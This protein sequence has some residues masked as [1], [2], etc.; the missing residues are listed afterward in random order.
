MKQIINDLQNKIITE[1]LYSRLCEERSE[2]LE[3]RVDSQRELNHYILDRIEDVL[4]QVEIL[5]MT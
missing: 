2:K 4:V 5:E 3:K 1:K